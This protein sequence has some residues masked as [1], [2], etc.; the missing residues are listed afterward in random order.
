MAMM[1]P[2]QGEGSPGDAFKMFIPMLIIFAIF[3]FMLLRPQQRKEKQR[4][5]MIEE[6]KSGARVLFSGGIIG[7]VVNVKESTFIIKI[8]EKVKI[9]V[10]RGAVVRVLEKGDKVELEDDARTR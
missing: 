8:A 6:I 4:K 2:K 3:Y 10:A 7:T 9:E 1:G 5:K